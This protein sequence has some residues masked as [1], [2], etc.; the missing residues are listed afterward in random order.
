MKKKQ[1]GRREHYENKNNKKEWC[2]NP[3]DSLIEYQEE[4]AALHQEQD[5]TS[6]FNNVVKEALMASEASQ[7]SNLID[8]LF[9]TIKNQ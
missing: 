5:R 6:Q 9:K 2:S 3:A 1:R 7:N 4:S 8:K